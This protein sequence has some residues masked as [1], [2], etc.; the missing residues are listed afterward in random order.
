[1]TFFDILLRH[2]QWAPRCKTWTLGDFLTQFE[3]IFGVTQCM[4]MYFAPNWGV[5][6]WRL[7]DFSAPRGLLRWKLGS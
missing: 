1:M 4:Y 7:S 6:G 2:C 5:C 3:L